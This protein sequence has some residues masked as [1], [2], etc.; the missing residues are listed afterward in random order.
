MSDLA[1]GPSGRDAWRCELKPVPL[2]VQVG[3]WCLQAHIKDGCNAHPRPVLSNS[4]WINASTP[5]RGKHS[6][7]WLSKEDAT[8]AADTFWH[9]LCHEEEDNG[10]NGSSA[11][12]GEVKGGPGD[13][14]T[15]TPTPNRHCG[16][17]LTTPRG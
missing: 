7:V 8:A 15:P 17:G 4:R 11:D 16:L 1:A 5:R 12:V 3:Q 9:Y 14:P 2:E 6:G 13:T 10:G